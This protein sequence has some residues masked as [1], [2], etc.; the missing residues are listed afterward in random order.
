MRTKLEKTA[1]LTSHSNEIGRVGLEY[2]D[3]HGPVNGLVVRL[4]GMPEGRF[5]EALVLISREEIRS[6]IG[7]PEPEP[8]GEAVPT[9]A[10]KVQSV[11]GDRRESLR[12]ATPAK[13]PKAKRSGKDA[14]AE[15]GDQ[16]AKWRLWTAKARAKKAAKSGAPTDRVAEIL[17]AGG[18]DTNGVF[19][20]LKEF[21]RTTDTAKARPAKKEAPAPS[22]TFRG[23]EPRGSEE[24]KVVEP[25]PPVV[26]KAV[27]P[28]E[29]AV[30]PAADPKPAEPP[31]VPVVVAMLKGEPAPEPV[32]APK[33][34]PVVVLDSED[35][36]A[37]AIEDYAEEHPVVPSAAPA[38]AARPTP[39]N[40]PLEER[41]ARAAAAREKLA[42]LAASRA[43]K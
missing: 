13:A 28:V 41:R 40:L 5:V 38:R 32:P 18:W 14:K 37:L 22:G 42:K 19:T 7:A 20:L 3:G 26:H 24:R 36:P 2:V 33:P 16:K 10:P 12:K 25:K 6:L 8:E 4:E 27:K 35:R 31:P 29:P 15:A 43:S 23:E 30:A 17:K 11:K 1:I 9:P 34:D 21:G 39:V